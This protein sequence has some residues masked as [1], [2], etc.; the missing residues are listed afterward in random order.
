MVGGWGDN[1]RLTIQLRMMGKVEG[2]KD[3]SLVLTT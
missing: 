1:S 3:W 2:V